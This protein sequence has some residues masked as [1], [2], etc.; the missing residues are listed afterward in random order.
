[1]I[2]ATFSNFFRASSSALIKKKSIN[3]NYFIKKSKS[4]YKRAA[5]FAF[6][7]LAAKN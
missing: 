3:E 1:L 6:L 5:S 2:S 7:L 4:S